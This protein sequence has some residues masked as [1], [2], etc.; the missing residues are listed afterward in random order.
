[1]LTATAT[2]TAKQ[3]DYKMNPIKVEILIKR[4]DEYV[5]ITHSG[6]DEHEKKQITENI[7][8]ALSRG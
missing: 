5:D 6:L 1:M 2:A 8:K 7:G 3:E 4:D